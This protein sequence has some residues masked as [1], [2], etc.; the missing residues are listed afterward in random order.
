[1]N[2]EF[3]AFIKEQRKKKILTQK[4]LASKL[5]ISDKA[6]SKWEVGDSYPDISLLIPI[7][8]IFEISVDELLKGV[9]QKKEEKK[10]MIKL[11]LLFNIAANL[12]LIVLVLIFLALVMFNSSETSSIF[13]EVV[14]IKEYTYTSL[15]IILGLALIFGVFNSLLYKKIGRGD[16]SEEVINR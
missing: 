14:D 3:G 5:N 10:N 11:L 9:K 7:A 13:V 2:T 12:L 6:V 16:N 15:F 4:D 8:N 1:M